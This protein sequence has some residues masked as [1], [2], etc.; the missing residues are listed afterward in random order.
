MSSPDE[1]E[2]I[3]ELLWNGYYTLETTAVQAM[4]ILWSEYHDIVKWLKDEHGQT[5]VDLLIILGELTKFVA[6]LPAEYR[7]KPARQVYAEWLVAE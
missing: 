2:E 3:K 7:H 5:E 1:R 4:E 6:S